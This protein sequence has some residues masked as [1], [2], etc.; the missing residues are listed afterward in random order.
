MQKIDVGAVRE[1]PENILI[2]K[3]IFY[4]N[5]VIHQLIDEV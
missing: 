2:P 3:K 5:P 1:P 4:N